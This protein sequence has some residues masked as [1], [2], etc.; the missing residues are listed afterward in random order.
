[1]TIS[2]CD[3][4]KHGAPEGVCDTMLP[5]HGVPPQPLPS[6][7]ILSADKNKVRSGGTVSVSLKAP[8]GQTFKGFLLQ[9]RDTKTN[10][11]VGSFVKVSGA[12]YKHINCNGGKN[13]SSVFGF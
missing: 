12:K 1:M 8:Q 10:K 6:P 2:Y 5:D 9:A 4:F 3:S 11:P 7:Y 13:V